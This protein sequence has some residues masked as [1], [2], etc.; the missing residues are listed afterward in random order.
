MIDAKL[1]PMFDERA[2]RRQIE[3]LKRGNETKHGNDFSIEEKIPQ[4][5]NT[6]ARDEAGKA[7]GVNGRY[8][9]MARPSSP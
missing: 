7:A 8:V 5:R 9:D 6:Q 2:K 3:A 4:S 1:R